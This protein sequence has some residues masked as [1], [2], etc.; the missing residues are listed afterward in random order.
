[1]Q[2]ERNKNHEF[3]SKILGAGKRANQF[4]DEACCVQREI[5]SVEQSSKRM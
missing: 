1:L 2:T 3:N 4:N 5:H